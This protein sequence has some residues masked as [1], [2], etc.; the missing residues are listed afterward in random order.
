MWRR[1]PPHCTELHV[2]KLPSLRALEA[3]S[4]RLDEQELLKIPWLGQLVALPQL[5]RVLLM[6]GDISPGRSLI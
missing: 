2:T 4:E 6:L 3:S 1:S 5:I